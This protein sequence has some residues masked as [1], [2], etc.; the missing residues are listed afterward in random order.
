MIVPDPAEVELTVSPRPTWIKI[1]TSSK[2]LLSLINDVDMA[3]A[4]SGKIDLIRNRTRPKNFTYLDAGHR[5]L[6]R[7]TAARLVLTPNR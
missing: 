3:K 2:F 5:S 4:E 1:D 6:C 7:K